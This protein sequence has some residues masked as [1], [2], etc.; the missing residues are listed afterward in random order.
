[1]PRFGPISRR[2]LVQYLR[3]LGFRGPYPGGRHEFMVRGTQRLM[4]PNP[5]GAEIGNSLLSRILRNAKI[6]RE[7]WESL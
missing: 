2:D 7:E 4:L 6:S 5:H 1:M 3:R